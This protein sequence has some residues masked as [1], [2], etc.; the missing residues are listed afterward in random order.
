LPVHFSP[1][2]H[3]LE[4]VGEKRIL[5]RARLNHFPYPAQLPFALTPAL[6]RRYWMAS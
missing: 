6:R 5:T 3:A 4:V 2:R 1:L